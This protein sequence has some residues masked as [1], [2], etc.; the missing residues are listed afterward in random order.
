MLK[1]FLHWVLV[2]FSILLT[3]KVVPGVKIDGFKPAL[4]AAIVLGA[5]NVIVKPILVVLTFPITVLTLGLFLLV[6]N[7]IIVSLAGYLVPG[8]WVRG[9]WA[10]VF[11][12][13]V[14]SI[15]SAF[16]DRVLDKFFNPRSYQHSFRDETPYF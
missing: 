12:S 7:A 15:C 16:A 5:L 3:S 13:I 2:A 10:A 1:L 14:I 4:I 9:F 11:A 8:F 6:I